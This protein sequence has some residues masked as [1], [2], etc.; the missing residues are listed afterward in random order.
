MNVS[1]ITDKGLCQTQTGTPYYASP[2][3]WKDQPYGPKSDIWSL[4]CVIYEMIALQPPFLADDME[5][6]YKQVTKGEYPKLPLKYSSDLNDLIR[7]LLQ[8]DPF[9]RPSC[10]TQI[11]TQKKYLI[12]KWWSVGTKT[13]ALTSMIKIHNSF[14]LFACLKT[15][16]F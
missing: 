5:G 1:K 4:G 16:I 3:V 12:W 8:T 10:C 2:E 7:I 14:K 15:Y 13:E 6:L 9:K 11:F